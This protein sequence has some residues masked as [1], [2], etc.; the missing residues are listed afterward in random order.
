MPVEVVIKEKEIAIYIDRERMAAWLQKE[1][2]VP[3][4]GDP[5]STS[6]LDEKES[7]ASEVEEENREGYKTG[8][9]TKKDFPNPVDVPDRENGEEQENPVDGVNLFDEGP[10]GVGG[11]LQD[12]PKGK[13]KIK[14]LRDWL[15]RQKYNYKNFCLFLHGLKEVAGFALS[16]PVIGLTQK[17]EPSIFQLATRYHSYW[18]SAKD[19]IAKDYERFLLAQLADMGITIQMVKDELEGEEIDPKNLPKGIEV[20]T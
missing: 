10:N 1:G 9:G 13:D 11:T 5:N 14:D 4:D 20:A 6:D 15:K 17:K 12:D 2:P 7:I 3:W 8:D 18:M 16:E 19:S